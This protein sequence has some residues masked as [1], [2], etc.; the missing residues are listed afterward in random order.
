M[1]YRILTAL[2]LPTLCLA[3]AQCSL[4][5]VRGTWVAYYVGS[6]T[7]AAA[8]SWSP[9][10]TPT[11]QL[12]VETID[13]QG[14]FTGTEYASVGG[15][16]V[17]ATLSGNSQVNA[18]CTASN[19]FTMSVAGTGKLPGTGSERLLILNNGT[20]MRAM[21]THGLL[22]SPTGIGYYRRVSWSEPHCTQDMVHGVYGAT[23]EGA[24]V[25]P[26]PGQ[27]QPAPYQYSQIG[28]SVWDYAGRGPGAATMS[29]GGNVLPISFPEGALTVNADCTGTA[30]S[31][32]GT[33]NQLV[34]LNW[35]DEMLFITMQTF[36][37]SP[38]MIGKYKRMSTT[39]AE[40]KW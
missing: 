14:R 35:G 36:G 29:L 20:E 6:I 12:M 2:A 34:V 38:V 26:P 1:V 18:D 16:T 37:G 19:T 15:Q 40:L 10:A 5:T 27:S 17:T 31:P 21:T 39:P 28:I 30:K 24:F 25:M 11:A 22:G 4:D 23:F 32:D 3:Q 13:Y 7:T 33:V 8:G 9:E